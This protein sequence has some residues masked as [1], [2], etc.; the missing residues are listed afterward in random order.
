MSVSRPTH[1]SARPAALA[2]AGVLDAS[3]EEAFDRITCLAARV[4]NVPYAV[5][6]LRDAEGTFTK[7]C[8]GPGLAG[9][10]LARE[11]RPRGWPSL[12]DGPLHI[13]DLA[14]DPRFA[15]HPLF[16]LG[17]R[18]GLRMYAGVPLVTGDGEALGTL[19]VLDTRARTLGAHEQNLLHSLAGLVLGE[20]E[21]R[22]LRLDLARA[23]EQEAL[24]GDLARL[25]GGSLTPEE[26]ARQALGRLHG[27]LSL[28][29]SALLRRTREA[30]E[31]SAEVGGRGE[32]LRALGPGGTGWAAVDR[33]EPL[34]L[35]GAWSVA[36]AFPELV[37]AGLGALAWLPLPGGEDA[38]HALAFLRMAESP[39]TPG[40]RWALEAAARGVGVALE[41]AEHNR[42]LERAALTDPLTGL[43]NR[44]AFDRALE[45]ADGLRARGGAGYVLALVDLDGMRRVND[46]YGRA[47]GDDLLREFARQLQYPDVT[48]YR[49]G[50]DEYALLHLSPGLPEAAAQALVNRVAGAVR[51][52]RSL[53]YPVGASVGVAT[54]PDDAPG[55]TGALRAALRRMH[56][57]KRSRRGAGHGR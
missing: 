17:S 40:E 38:A 54:V 18:L 46:E 14:A 32:T 16:S 21:R 29:G 5:L 1:E 51:F 42:R 30:V 10:G 43:G 35:E 6:T 13:E 56:A 8:H 15:R 57:Q 33:E 37:E 4:L 53:A 34:F 27:T 20:L 47:R 45:D 22:A 23:R 48:A 31:V 28:E 41:R 26:A 39:W 36:R 49:L 24:L 55:A 7:S 19:C 52:T 50:G 11:E 3:P 25:V 44:H 2:R 12:P 9:L